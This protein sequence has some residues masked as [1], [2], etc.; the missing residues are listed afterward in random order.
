MTDIVALDV[1]LQGGGAHIGVE[2]EEG[3]GGGP[4]P[5]PQVLQGQRSKVR[6]QNK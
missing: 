4:Q 1:Q 3:V 5:L 2:V 6:H